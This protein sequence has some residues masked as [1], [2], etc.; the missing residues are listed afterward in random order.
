MKTYFD[1]GTLTPDADGI[2]LSR[3]TDT[4]NV[5]FDFDT[6]EIDDTTNED[7]ASN[8]ATKTQR[9]V[10][11]IVRVKQSNTYASIVSAIVNDRYSAD[12]AQALSANYNEA[13]DTDSEIDDDKRAEYVAEYVAF[14]AW[15]KKAKDI[16]KKV[17][18]KLGV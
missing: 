12:D 18:A 5:Y 3:Y 17:V 8:A 2:L 15:R 13:K 14:Q 11:E 9:G 16:A 1:I 10:C 4:L 6:E 7:T